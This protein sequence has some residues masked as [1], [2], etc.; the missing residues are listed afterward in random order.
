MLSWLITT[1]N[2]NLQGIISNKW[3]NASNLLIFSFAI[4]SFILR[5]T[6]QFIKDTF[7]KIIMVFQIGNNKKVFNSIQ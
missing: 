2:S 7:F 1:I 3:F 6:M 4:I 5:Q